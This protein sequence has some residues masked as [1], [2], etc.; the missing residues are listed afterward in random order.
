MTIQN[1]N[2]TYITVIFQPPASLL[3]ITK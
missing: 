2:T 1:S 3:P